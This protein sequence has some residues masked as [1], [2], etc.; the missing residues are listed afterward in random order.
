MRHCYCESTTNRAMCPLLYIDLATSRKGDYVKAFF[1]IFAII[2]LL[3]VVHLLGGT[4]GVFKATIDGGIEASSSY[5]EE[6]GTIN[7]TKTTQQIRQAWDGNGGQQHS[8]VQGDYQVQ[9]A[10]FA[11]PQAVPSAPQKVNTAIS[12]QRV[13][14]EVKPSTLVVYV[15]ADWTSIPITVN[16]SHLKRSTFK[17]G[18]LSIASFP[19]SGLSVAPGRVFHVTLNDGSDSVTAQLQAPW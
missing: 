2:G 14:F 8:S 12:G 4:S 11:R 17:S 9:Q 7:W 18:E 3:F 13:T 19:L 10:P 1:W 15:K 5:R 6:H 16:G